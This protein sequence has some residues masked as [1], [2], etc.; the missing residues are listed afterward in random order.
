MT[1]KSRKSTAAADVKPET[2]GR[3]FSIPRLR[4]NC[5]EL[6]G[7]STSTFDGATYGMT[8]EYTVE[9]IRTH[10]ETWGKKGVK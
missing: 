3:K 9:A 8:G 10:I 7:V 5:R 6:F 1:A 4:A 2:A